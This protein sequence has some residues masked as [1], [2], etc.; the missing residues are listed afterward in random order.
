M[1]KAVIFD[2]DGTLVQTEELKARSYAEA[3]QHLSSSRI[4]DQE[5]LD[6]F[7]DFVGLSR[8]EVV[9]GLIAAFTE[10]LLPAFEDQNGKGEPADWVLDER[11][12]RYRSMIGNTELLSKYFCP[13]NLGLFH[14]LGERGVQRALATMSNPAEAYQ[15]LDALGIRQDLNLI[16]TR[17]DVTH[18]KP[19]PEIYE[20]AAEKLALKV[21]ECL[22][23]EDSVNGIKAAQNA[24]MQVF[25]VTNN[26][27]RKSVH[28]SGLLAGE[29]VVDDLTTL[30][31][32]VLDHIKA[33]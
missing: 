6:R 5:V 31:A 20:L 23:I 4:S 15:V 30:R 27:T 33:N 1:I 13:Y 17:Q 10:Q 11:L 21:T 18:G 16:L 26:I 9:K 3:L 25:A 8:T 2:L 29:F 32:T 19:N 7:G 24:G 12:R 28:E 14:S 22:V